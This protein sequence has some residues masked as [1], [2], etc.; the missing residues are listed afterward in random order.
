MGI[1]ESGADW[2]GEFLGLNSLDA[3]PGTVK[4]RRGGGNEEVLVGCQ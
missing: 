3:R 2:E 1:C 4:M